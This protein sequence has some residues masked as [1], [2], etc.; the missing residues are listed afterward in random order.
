MIILLIFYVEGYGNRQQ[1]IVLRNI[2]V[3]DIVFTICVY[4]LWNDL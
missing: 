2:K 4:S 3:L 1:N